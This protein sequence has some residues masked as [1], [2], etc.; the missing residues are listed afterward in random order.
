MKSKFVIVDG[1]S[2][3]YRAFFAPGMEGSLHSPK[4]EPTGTIF[5]FTKILFKLLERFQ[6]DYFVVTMDGPRSKLRRKKIDDQYKQSR[7]QAPQE[8]FIQIDRI[9]DLL[10]VL[11]IPMLQ[12]DGYEADDLIATLVDICQSKELEI[13]IVSRDKDLEQLLG[14]G[15]VMFDP[16]KIETI[17]WQDSEKR[18]GIRIGQLVDYWAMIG[19]KVD[20]I[21]GIDGIGPG[22]AAK[23][24]NEYNDLETI[25]ERLGSLSPKQGVSLRQFQDSGRMRM[26]QRLVALDRQVPIDFDPSLLEWNGLKFTDEVVELFQGLGMKSFL[27]E[28]R[29]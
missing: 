22:R 5:I 16:F 19:D 24:L 14:P 20:N 2:Q 17:T 3:I 21:P 11:K 10:K 28:Y 1:H 6:P 25:C 27:R 15:V 29:K 13:I 26:N 9:K 23:L 8:L 18:R 7:G 4:G 12:M